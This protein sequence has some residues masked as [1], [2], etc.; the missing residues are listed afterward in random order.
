M[1]RTGCP[2]DESV[3]YY[4]DVLVTSPYLGHTC[5]K[6]GDMIEHRIATAKRLGVEDFDWVIDE[7]AN[8]DKEMP[9]TVAAWVHDALTYALGQVDPGSW[10]E[11]FI[12]K[13]FAVLEGKEV[14]C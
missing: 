1:I 8:E 5:P 10:N 13:S 6:C 7:W 3:G 9:A 12:R 14:W 4:F 11:A 2:N